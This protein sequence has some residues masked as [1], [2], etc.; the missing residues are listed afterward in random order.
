MLSRIPRRLILTAATVIVFAVTVLLLMRLI[1]PPHTAA[2]HVIIGTVATFLS[3]VVLFGVWV[4]IT[5]QT[6]FKRRLKP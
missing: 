6:F 1:P 5:P 4:G 3:L 2:D